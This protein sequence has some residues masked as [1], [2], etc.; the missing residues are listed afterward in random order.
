[1]WCVSVNCRP[2]YAA[3]PPLSHISLLTDNHTFATYAFSPPSKPD[4]TIP[5]EGRA[6]ERLPSAPLRASSFLAH[7][8]LYRTQ[9]RK[10]ASTGPGRLDGLPRDDPDGRGTAGIT[11]SP[12]SDL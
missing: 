6:C 8:K 12:P 1:M 9:V 4:V 10:L 11:P 5:S 3:A 2:A 7:P